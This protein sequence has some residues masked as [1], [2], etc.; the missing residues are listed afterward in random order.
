MFPKLSRADV[1]LLPSKWEGIPMTVI[2]AMGTGLPV[3][4]SRVGGCRT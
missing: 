3:I 2:E 1:F 4:A